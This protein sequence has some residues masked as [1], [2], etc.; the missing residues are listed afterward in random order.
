M[1]SAIEIL[2]RDLSQAMAFLKKKNPRTF[3]SRLFKRK[4]T[5]QWYIV[6]GASGVGKTSLLLNS[7]LSFIDIQGREVLLAHPTQ[8]CQWLFAN[9]A[10]F[11]D[12]TGR[13]TPDVWADWMK[14]LSQVHGKPPIHGLIV[15]FDL[16]YSQ[17]GSKQIEMIKQ[18]LEA[19]NPYIHNVPVYV[20]LTQCD[21]IA[22]FVEF[23]EDLGIEEQKEIFGFH[24]SG[25]MI[26]QDFLS[27][28]EEKFDALIQRL[29]QRVIWRLHQERQVDKKLLIKHF[30]L[31]LA[32]LKENTRELVKAL[33]EVAHLNLM[34][35]YFTSSLQKGR[36]VNYLDQEEKHD[37]P[38]ASQ[39][40]RGAGLSVQPS[41]KRFFIESLFNQ[42]LN[43]KTVYQI[44]PKT[45]ISHYFVY[46]LSTFFLMG[47]LVLGY[48]HY[49]K[50]L[51]LAQETGGWLQEVDEKSQ[52]L[53][54]T[55]NRLNQT[56]ERLQ[57]KRK[58]QLGGVY[59]GALERLYQSIDSTYFKLLTSRFSRQL[60]EALETVL[61][62]PESTPSDYYRTLAVYLMLGGKIQRN[63][64]FIQN[65]FKTYWDSNL[66]GTPFSYRKDLLRY[67][68][69]MLVRKEEM[70]LNAS[71]IKKTRT[72]LNELP[73]NQLVFAVL[74]A[75]FLKGVSDS[76][77][78]FPLWYLKDSQPPALFTREHVKTVHDTKIP[79]IY[80]QLSK[81]DAVI[82]ETP[83]PLLKGF[84]KNRQK[85]IIAQAKAYYLK[86]Y[87]G[88][89]QKLLNINV[90]MDPMGSDTFKKLAD[91]TKQLSD[92][93]WTPIRQ[94]TRSI[95][96]FP[97]FNQSV[98]PDFGEIN[99]VIAQWKAL[100]VQDALKNMDAY[101]S[102]IMDSHSGA[103]IAARMRME[104]NGEK[105]PITQL[106]QTAD[107]LPT[108]MR[109]SFTQLADVVWR[110][111]LGQ[112][113]VYLNEKWKA[114][115][116]P[117]YEEYLKDRYPLFQKA[118]A[119]VTLED[120]TQFFSQDGLLTQF[121][122]RY[123]QFFVDQHKFYWEW[124]KVDGVDLGVAQSTLEA[125]IRGM[126]IKKMFF[127]HQ[128]T[129]PAFQFSVELTSLK[130]RASEG[131][132]QLND[133]S[134][135][136]FGRGSKAKTFMWPGQPPYIASIEILGGQEGR[137][138]Y[139]LKK[140]PWAL[141]RLLDEA[142]LGTSL[143]SK[144]LDVVFDLDHE[145]LSG[146]LVVDT[147]VNP[148]ISGILNAFRCPESL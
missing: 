1:R 59:L 38:L 115:V 76:P 18:T 65:W 72:R 9:Q 29:N 140:G 144:R 88:F 43:T 27:Q 63:A 36:P 84:Q 5:P 118:T 96:N 107:S 19:I 3:F 24:F 8:H 46:A 131:I 73:M 106:K 70:S 23:F 81:G 34:G 10:V 142:R 45:P 54:N 37:F 92:M 7:G 98:T 130:G 127:S 137:L 67:L 17:S 53:L 55:L 33:S 44:K 104:D 122:E 49:Q 6:M 22:G 42:V 117:F 2:K 103:F 16:K 143:D 35:L 28:F 51:L 21:F 56:R 31:Q 50:G 95:P 134:V 25:A 113:R 120:M 119:E 26:Q 145:R 111:V 87:H 132:F 101:L 41:H 4:E 86:Q 126:L 110:S 128:D 108:P 15:A 91:L 52:D 11:L 93:D 75:D 147:E 74:S 79:E 109:E 40:L 13:Y 100:P 99:G 102:V 114:L 123:I 71:L 124:R 94:N 135:N 32:A 148:L 60:K 77:A 78:D 20:S 69:E 30:P 125:F 48:Q 133:Q 121:F 62:T 66:Q 61:N 89:W 105:D 83:E 112:T 139:L 129:V 68:S 85:V 12:M 146:L 136:Y 57:K 90:Q 64:E 80:H 82:Q 138:V 39:R 97:E 141:F 14:H 116:F 47:I 58:E